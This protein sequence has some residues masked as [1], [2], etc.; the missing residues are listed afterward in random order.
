MSNARISAATSSSCP[1]TTAA[2]PGDTDV[3]R[4]GTE[5]RAEK[6]RFSVSRG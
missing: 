3:R 2:V 1:S 4:Y 6:L 5:K